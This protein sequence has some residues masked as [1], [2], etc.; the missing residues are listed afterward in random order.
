MLPVSGVSV[1]WRPA[2]GHMDLVLAESAPGL[3]GAAEYLTA[4]TDADPLTLPVGDVDWL[5]V[6]RRQALLGDSLVAEGTCHH[7]GA[8]VD[9]HFGLAAYLEHH[10]PRAS[11][12][13]ATGDGWFTLR[14]VVFRPPT[15]ADVLVVS[16]SPRAQHDLLDRCVRGRVS[17]R[18]ALAVEAALA[19][20]APLL[21]SEVEG[22][23]PE[24]AQIVLLDV[25]ARELCLAEL[26]FLAAGVYDDINLI[27]SVYHWD[28][29]RILSLPTAR[30]RRYADMIAGRSTADLAVPVG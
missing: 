15:T 13:V 22:V 14:E 7:C 21:R 23:C 2:D 16:G 11:R 4:C 25:D 10:R 12:A 29:D 17:G 19:K 30:R 5:V 28:E 24:C 1:S 18:T 6:A 27:A 26:R 9:V 20:V 8:G 3:A